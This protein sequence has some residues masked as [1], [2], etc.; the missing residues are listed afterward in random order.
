MEHLLIV[1]DNRD[2][3]EYLANLLTY[4]GYRITEAEDGREA[5]DRVR[6]HKPDLVICD[7]LMPVIDGY[8]FVRRLRLEPEIATTRIIFYTAH[9]LEDEA[10]DLAAAA[11]ISRV[12]EKPCEPETILKHV[13]EALEEPAGSPADEDIAAFS[14]EHLRLVTDKLYRRTGEIDQLNQRLAAL[15]ELNLQLASERNPHQ[16]LNNVCH[17]ARELIGAEYAALA[18]RDNHSEK[19]HYFTTSG[20]SAEHSGDL[21][22][23]TLGGGILGEVMYT[24]SIRRYEDID[25]SMKTGLP[26]GYP[27]CR[28]LI[29]VPV[30]SLTRT[31]GWLCLTNKIGEEKFNDEDEQLLGILCAQTGR[32]YENGSL[33]SK[34]RFHSSQ[35]EQEIS[36]RT[37]VQSRLETQYDV[38]RILSRIMTF[39]EAI[40]ELM[41]AIATHMGFDVG[42]LW[43]ADGEIDELRCVSTWHSPNIP[44]LSDFVEKSRSLVI[45]RHRG[46]SAE[47]WENAEPLWLPDLLDE[48][49]RYQTPRELVEIYQSSDLHAAASLPIILRNR[50]WGVMTFYSREIMMEE[51]GILEMLTAIT[52]CSWSGISSRKTS[53]A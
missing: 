32:I 7:I 9:Y 38:S 53:N 31:Y 16:L 6:E 33:Y 26:D 12:L 35:L 17:G 25:S 40:P 43:E 24:N 14:N 44:A 39:E 36:R 13:R 21:K 19:L 1:D 37:R 28:N 51:P 47:V 23:D 15:V 4:K 50:V 52:R 45:P 42:F 48:T 11:G 10:K 49:D 46:L 3:R 41:E 5:L 27:E 2:N 29:A 34:I 22:P 8:D 18:V 30:T 20:I